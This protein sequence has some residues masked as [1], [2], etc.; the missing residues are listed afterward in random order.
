MLEPGQKTLV[1]FGFV[2]KPV[3][4]RHGETHLMFENSE[5]LG[6]EF[7]PGTAGSRVR[8]EFKEVKSSKETMKVSRGG[9]DVENKSCLLQQKRG[10]ECQNVEGGKHTHFAGPLSP[11]AQRVGIGVITPKRKFSNVFNQEFHQT[12]KP[13]NF[14]GNNGDFVRE[15]PSKKIRF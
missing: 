4:Y 9:E 8:K 3:K 13:V 14:S 2:K 7:K 12:L 15:S 11:A 1:G 6:I 5:P 10:P